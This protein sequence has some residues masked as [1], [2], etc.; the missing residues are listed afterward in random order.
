MPAAEAT[1][2]VRQDGQ[3]V[4]DVRVQNTGPNQ[5]DIYVGLTVNDPEGTPIDI[6]PKEVD[7]GAGASTTVTFENTASGSVAPRAGGP[8]AVEDTFAIPG[9]YSITVRAWNAWNPNADPQENSF[10][11]ALMEPLTDPITITNAIEVTEQ[12]PLIP[13]IPEEVAGIDVPEAIRGPFNDLSTPGKAVA[14]VGPLA[15]AGAITSDDVD[16]PQVRGRM[17]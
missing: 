3:P 8:Q 7:L 13:D 10:G 14:I 11:I 5:N 4:V 12:Q 9:T 2:E 6:M 17:R 1:V 16:L 15:L